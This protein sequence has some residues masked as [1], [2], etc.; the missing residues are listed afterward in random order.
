MCSF[1]VCHRDWFY[2]EQQFRSIMSGEVEKP[3]ATPSLH[4]SQTTAGFKI[5][6]YES[7]MIDCHAEKAT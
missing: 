5:A 3:T 2:K 1:I 4:V 6:C 7:Q